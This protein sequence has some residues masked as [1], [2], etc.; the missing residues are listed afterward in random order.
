MSTIVFA[1][2][3]GGVGKSTLFDEVAWDL[4]SRGVPVTTYQLDNQASFYHGTDENP[5]ADIILV[6]TP[7]RLDSDVV[8]ASNEADLVVVPIG[9]S[10]RDLG[11]AQSLI[12]QLTVPVG[13][14]LNEHSPTRRASRSLEE[15]V[16]GNGWKIIAK[17]PNAAAFTATPEPATGVVTHSSSSA[18]AHAIRHLTNQILEI[19]R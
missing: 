8:A 13:I 5:D 4:E 10:P 3:K 17:V 14:V 19:V 11:P 16:T 1:N 9:P 18:A 2:P 15:I 7:A 12:E 6:D